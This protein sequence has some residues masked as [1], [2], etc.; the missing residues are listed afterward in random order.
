MIDGGSAPDSPWS[1]LGATDLSMRLPQLPDWPWPDGELELAPIGGGLNNQNW[2][3]D[4]AEVGT[5]F[6]KVPGLGTEAF[7][8]RAVAHEAAVTAAS[9]GI[10]PPMHYYDAGTGIEVSGFLDGYRPLTEFELSGT[11]AVF[12][13]V[14]TYKKLHS[15]PLLSRTRTVFEEIDVALDQLGG[16]S[17]QP[18]WVQE[19]LA[20]WRHAEQKLHAVGFDLAPC[21]NDPNFTNMMEKSGSP[22]QLVD[23]EFAANNDPSYEVLGLIGYYPVPAH[24]RVAVIEEYFGRYTMSLEARM[25]VMTMAV[26]IRFGLW[27]IGQST[28]KDVDFDYRK[29]GMWNLMNARGEMVDPRWDAWIDAL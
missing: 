26:M 4:V 11:D 14:R 28:V 12:D 5:F 9:A 1:S 17:G 24:T 8:D 15:A 19:L 25:H 16:A 2:R 29:Y 21:H 7:T 23:W 3:L 27:A 22:M 6:V 20:E 10:A 13:V 18:P